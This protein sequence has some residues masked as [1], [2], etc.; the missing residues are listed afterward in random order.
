MPTLLHDAYETLRLNYG[1]L[2]RAAGKATQEDAAGALVPADNYIKAYK[3]SGFVVAD[4]VSTAEAGQQASQTAVETFL[5]D[6]FTTPDTWSVKQSAEQVLST[7]NLRLY[8]HSHAFNQSAHT[9]EQKGFLCTFSG[10]VLKSHTA[11]LFH[12]GDS[13]IYLFRQ[14][15]LVQQTQDHRFETAQNRSFLARA[16]GMGNHLQLDYQQIPLEVGDYFLLS[17]DGLHDFVSD[18]EIAQV[19]SQAS[20][21]S[22]NTLTDVLEQLYQVAMAQGCDDNLSLVLVQVEGL[23]NLNKNAFQ[24]QLVQLPFPPAFGPGMKVDGYEII[25]EVFASSRSHLYLAKDLESGQQVALKAPSANFSDDSSY[26]ERFIREE[27]IGQRISSPHVV[28]VIRPTRPKTF[29]Y[30][31]MDFVEGVSLEHWMEQQTQPI[32]PKKVLQLLEQ[33][34]LGIQAF[35]QC[36][37]I[38]QDLKPGNIMLQRQ[39]NKSTGEWEEK[40]VIIDFGSVFVSGVAEIFIP[41]DHEAA[42]GTASYSDP[43]YLTG[44]NSAIQG[45]IYSIATIAYELF[46]GKLPYGTAI[47]S[48]QVPRDFDALRYIPAQQVNP[49]IPVWLDRALEKGVHFDL[50]ERY[51]QLDAFMQDIRYPNPDFLRDE[52]KKQSQG[53]RLLFWQLLSGFWFVTLILVIYLFAIH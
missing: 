41:I 13:R 12:I 52:V 7:I 32:R 48:C 53:N 17:T 40:A 18:A 11:H 30:Y 21:E 19:L 34:T 28:R 36:E 50:Q 37:T 14:Q 25:Q 49:R 33:I 2:S 31:V 47:E 22:G 16:L 51:S 26:I 42:L 35:H 23:P 20:D 8:R 46:T 3:G 10:L 44:K 4:G 45:D 29:L 43:L 6:Y 24:E 1:V 39:Q 15:Q 38:H 5:K 27:W 9:G